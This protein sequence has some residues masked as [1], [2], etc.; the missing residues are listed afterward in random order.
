MV[1]LPSPDIVGS[2]ALMIWTFIGDSQE[3]DPQPD[4]ELIESLIAVG[5]H[6]TSEAMSQ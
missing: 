5:T 4:L 1:C 2:A 3:G 6:L